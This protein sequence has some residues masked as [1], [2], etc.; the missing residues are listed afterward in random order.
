VDS[1]QAA[2]RSD[3]A[4]SSVRSPPNRIPKGQVIAHA[5]T[6][7]DSCQKFRLCLE[8]HSQAPKHQCSCLR[9]KVAR[10]SKHLPGREPGKAGVTCCS[11]H[12]TF[13]TCR[14][15][16][17]IAHPAGQHR[18]A[19]P[20]RLAVRMGCQVMG[21]RRTASDTSAPGATAR[22]EQVLLSRIGGLFTT[23]SGHVFRRSLPLLFNHIIAISMVGQKMHVLICPLESPLSFLG[24]VAPT[25]TGAYQHS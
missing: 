3:C 12:D 22:G 8:P 15:L 11:S 25:A 18:V 7:M 16:P 17:G 24:R 21:E 13:K 14:L 9:A 4:G 1:S 10:F 5:M 2:C 6:R 20:A 23:A 19:I